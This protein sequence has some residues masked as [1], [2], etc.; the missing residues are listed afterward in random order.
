MKN[1]LFIL[2][3]N[4]L[5]PYSFSQNSLGSNDSS[6][7]DTIWVG[8]ENTV[9]VILPESISLFDI[10]N[11]DYIGKIENGS[12]MF[13]KATNPFA[14][15]STMLIQY[16]NTIF[17]GYVAYREKIDKPFYDFRA[18]PKIDLTPKTNTEKPPKLSLGRLK[19]SSSNINLKEKNSDVIVK[20]VNVFNDQQA[21]Y[22]KFEVMNQSTIIYQVDYVSFIYKTHVKRKKRNQLT[23]QQQEIEPIEFE[24]P[25]MIGAGGMESFMYAIPLYSATENDYLEVVFREGKGARLITMNIPAKKILTANLL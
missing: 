16:G 25:M 8:R 1:L 11:K 24:A 5:H 20:L 17:K 15:P 18:L 14:K 19:E 12:I 9:Y 22:L 2:L 3:L 7:V 21:T 10:G 13:L 23:P 4:C 6:L